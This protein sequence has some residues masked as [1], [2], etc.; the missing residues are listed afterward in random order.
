MRIKR[1]YHAWQAELVCSVDCHVDQKLMPFMHPVE[2]PDCDD[3]TV[4]VSDLIR[5]RT[6]TVHN[7]HVPQRTAY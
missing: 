3:R 6:K 2:D 1:Q 5:D 7:L 4:W